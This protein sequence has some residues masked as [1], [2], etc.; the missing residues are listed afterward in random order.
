MGELDF[1]RS[2]GQSHE[3]QLT[4]QTTPVK[5]SGSCMSLNSF[6]MAFPGHLPRAVVGIAILA[7]LPTPNPFN[8]IQLPAPLT[9]GFR[10]IRLMFPGIS[11]DCPDIRKEWCIQ[12]IESPAKIEK[13][14]QNRY[15][16]WARIDELEGK[17]LRVVTLEDKITIHNA[18]PDRGF[19][20]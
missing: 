18:F 3:N 14:E 7:M 20:L 6:S 1:K 2:P 16:F 8:D 11:C 5:G 17:Y 10:Q 13:Q 4:S 12:V 19:R 9:P 15:R